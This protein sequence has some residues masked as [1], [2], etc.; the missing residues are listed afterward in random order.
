MR[1]DYTNPRRSS[2]VKGGQV[3]DRLRG[4]RCSSWMLVTMALYLHLLNF[5]L[6]V[7]GKRVF[8]LNPSHS[9][10]YPFLGIFDSGGLMEICYWFKINVISTQMYAGWVS[11]LIL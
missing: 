10:I 5:A 11:E 8:A 9:N 1:E 3:M 7:L 2:G 4:C 6:N